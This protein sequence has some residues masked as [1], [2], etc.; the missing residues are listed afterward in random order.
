MLSNFAIH[1]NMYSDNILHINENNNNIDSQSINMEFNNYT[2]DTH[3][4]YTLY[5]DNYTHNVLHTEFASKKNSD[6]V[7]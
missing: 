6:T 3:S 7:I 4:Y 1:N 5:D 2:A